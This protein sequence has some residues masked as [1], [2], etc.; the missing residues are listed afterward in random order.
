MTNTFVKKQ[1]DYIVKNAKITDIYEIDR[2][3]FGIEVFYNETIKIMVML[4]IAIILNKL[5]P[6]IIMFSLLI[7]IRPHIGGSHAKSLMECMVKSNLAFFIIYILGSIIPKFNLAF[8]LFFVISSIY[9]VFKY[10]P[11][12]PLRKKINTSYKKVKFKYIVAFTV[13]SWFLVSNIFL[14]SYLI[15]CGWLIIIYILIDFL[16]EVYKREKVK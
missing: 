1:V 11:V 15:N 2:I 16:K 10:K 5:L 3:R 12:N 14:S 8:Q 9:F 6:F 7:L 4:T 13:L